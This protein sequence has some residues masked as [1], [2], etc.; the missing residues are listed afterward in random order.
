MYIHTVRMS[1]LCCSPSLCFEGCATQKQVRCLKGD[2]MDGASLDGTRANRGLW[3][4]RVKKRGPCIPT[5][6]QALVPQGITRSK[7]CLLLVCTV[8]LHVLVLAIL[9]AIHAVMSPRHHRQTDNV[10]SRRIT[11]SRDEA[12]TAS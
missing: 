10:N 5:C 1:M 11:R 3:S 8:D 6:R 9:L 12:D 4:V 2:E 7:T